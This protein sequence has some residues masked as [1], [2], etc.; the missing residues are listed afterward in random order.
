ME[1]EGLCFVRRDRK[2]Y[3][4]SPEDVAQLRSPLR[5][6]VPVEKIET[7]ERRRKL[8]VQSIAQEISGIPQRRRSVFLRARALRWGLAASVLLS[9]LMGGM[10]LQA[11]RSE[12][13]SGD[14]LVASS[15]VAAHSTDALKRASDHRQFT[16]GKSSFSSESVQKIPVPQV[17]QL[18]QLGKFS[19][20]H[21]ELLGGLELV[22]T[23]G[24]SF[25]LVEN[26][27]S[28]QV[29][30]LNGGQ[31]RVE[32]PPGKTPRHVSVLTPHAQVEV[33]G[34]IFSVRLGPHNKSGTGKI[35]RVSSR[36]SVTE[37][38]V[39]RGV[40]LV[41]HAHGLHSLGAGES[42]RSSTTLQKQARLALDFPEKVSLAGTAS[43]LSA[44][45][46][47]ALL[48]EPQTPRN[49][50]H[51]LAEMAPVNSKEGRV[52]HGGGEKKT[53][54]LALQNHLLE[55]ALAHAERG[56]HVAALELLESLLKRYPSSPLRSSVRALR[57]KV[58]KV[59]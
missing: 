17:G 2:E 36:G 24:S 21:V 20:G 39:E 19:R 5:V 53:S 57:K 44:P 46:A 50:S 12:H 16:E 42:W 8:L 30:Y 13:A 3:D 38:F 18:V 26:R 40:V 54:T 35:D 9:V 33:K 27:L 10:F 4:L 7:I 15:R 34:T 51:T 45:Q 23:A 25:H 52:L 55:E 1:T 37:V 41:K 11:R 31:V 47:F 48:K 56:E 59:P 22:F 6:N 43:S 49:Q 29:I 28:H 58:L 14:H 32:V